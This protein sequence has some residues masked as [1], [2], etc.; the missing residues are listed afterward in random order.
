MIADA[1]A[2]NAAILKNIRT[3]KKRP[4]DRAKRLAAKSSALSALRLGVLEIKDSRRINPKEWARGYN[5]AI[6]AL[7]LLIEKIESGE[8]II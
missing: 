4:S 1:K 2:A 7:E 6:T 3:V 8:V 5:S